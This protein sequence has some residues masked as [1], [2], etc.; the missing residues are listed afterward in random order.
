MG[1]DGGDEKW[2]QA[3]VLSYSAELARAALNTST[4]LGDAGGVMLQVERPTSRRVT[5]MTYSDARQDMLCVR[6]G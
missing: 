5:T 3:A 2:S 6:L 4:R 1:D